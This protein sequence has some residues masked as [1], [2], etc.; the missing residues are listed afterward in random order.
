MEEFLKELQALCE[1]HNAHI[2]AY[3][4]DDPEGWADKLHFLVCTGSIEDRVVAPARFP[5]KISRNYEDQRDDK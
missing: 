1:K 5:A 3:G 2:L 4:G